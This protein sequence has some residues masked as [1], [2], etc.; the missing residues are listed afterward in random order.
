MEV[1]R[2]NQKRFRTHR[3][4]SPWASGL[5]HGFFLVMCVFCLF[6]IVL[7]LIASFTDE[8][9]LRTG[10]YTYFPK[11]W[12]TAAYR[13][14]FIDINQLF[15]AYGV[16]IVITVGGTLTSLFISSLVA[17]PMSRQD[18]P[19]RKILSFYVFFTILLNGGLVPWY[20]VYTQIIDLRDTIWALMIPGL[21]MNGFNVLIMRTFF[22]NSVPLSV[23]ESARIDGAGEW[24][25]FFQLVLP[26]SVSVLATIGM[27]TTLAY[28][29]D[30]FN[31]LIFISDSNYFS[32]QYLMTK[33]LL[34]IQFLS[35]HTENA[36][37]AK[38]ISEMPQN[39]I[40]MAMAV[41]G[42]GPIL[43][44]YPFFQKYLVKGLTV[45]SVKG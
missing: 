29:N 9:I 2:V 13:Y 7:V 40:I 6:P 3:E 19:Y 33:A 8:S 14:L 18:F 31:G 26:L 25:I 5:L 38:L 44:S 24:R 23:I 1:S 32:V 45:G 28:W 42:I 37:S 36:N 4:G 27:F 30:W 39:S 10:G 21:L 11:I 12:S 43:I 17:Y 20:L 22:S 35:S 15:R 34:N 16:T 41:I